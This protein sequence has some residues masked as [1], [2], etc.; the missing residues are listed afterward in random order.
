MKKILFIAIMIFMTATVAQAHERW[1]GTYGGLS[2]GGGLIT[3]TATEYDGPEDYG[4]YSMTNSGV[5]LGILAGHNWLHGPQGFYGIEVDL[6]WTNFNPERIFA[7]GDSINEAEWNWF[8]TIRARG[9]I[10]HDETLFFV[11]AGIAI[12]DADYRFGTLG[13]DATELVESGKLDIGYTAGA[14]VEYAINENMSLR[15][16]YLYIGLP[17]DEISEFALGDEPGDFVSSANIIR[18]AAIMD[19]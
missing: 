17:S 5:T 15:G 11:A 13:G 8:S 18:F 10:T 1:A 2:L 12:V 7:Q 19:F 3:A 4:E 9:G 16:E 6:N 14:G